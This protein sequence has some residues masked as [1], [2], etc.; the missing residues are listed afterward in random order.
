MKLFFFVFALLGHGNWKSDPP[1]RRGVCVV[2]F[3]T[4]VGER[5]ISIFNRTT[6]AGVEFQYT[7]HFLQRNATHTHT[8]NPNFHMKEVR[9]LTSADILSGN[10]TFFNAKTIEMIV[11][12]IHFVL[13]VIVG[14]LF[15]IIKCHAVSRNLKCMFYAVVIAIIGEL[16]SFISLLFLGGMGVISVPYLQLLY[17]KYINGELIASLQMEMS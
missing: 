3:F 17:L 9:A 8:K 6:R 14:H 10:F 7:N 12:Y 11:D 16:F 1:E 2:F 13:D 15:L 4:V 5:G